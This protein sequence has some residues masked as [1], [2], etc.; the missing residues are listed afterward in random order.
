MTDSGWDFELVLDGEP[1]GKGRPRFSRA[2]GHTYTPEKT[3]RFEERLAWAAQSVMARAP[4]FDGPLEMSIHAY[5][6]IPV[7]KPTKW[8]EQAKLGAFRPTKKP[9]IDNIVK[10][11]ADALNKVVYVDD[12]QIVV[13]TA[14]KYYSDRPRIEIFISNF[15]IM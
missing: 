3:A 14:A 7:S 4:L 8:K 11:V 5:F 1:I 15:V 9:D 6:S 2:T 10:G 13:L 12:T